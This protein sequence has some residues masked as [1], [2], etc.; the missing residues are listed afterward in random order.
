MNSETS[1]PTSIVGL[2]QNLRDET[3]TLLRQEVALAKAEV[4]DNLKQ[5][6]THA[7]TIATGGLVAYA[8][9][10]VL[11]MGLGHL[12]EAALVRAEFDP[13]LAQW[14]APLVVG[15]AVVLIGWGMVAKA[16]R[17]LS[18]DKIAP[19]ETIDSL[20]TDKKWA[21]AKLQ[22]SHESSS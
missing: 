10:I 21:Q 16:K 9:L 6:G 5:A 13:D 22:H 4:T 8:G 19:T 18:S 17:A 11:L 14:L 1:Q 3:T 7:A 12:L 20:K 2:L 15:V